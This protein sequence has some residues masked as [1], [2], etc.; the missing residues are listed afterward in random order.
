MPQILNQKALLLSLLLYITHSPLANFFISGVLLLGISNADYSPCKCENSCMC[1]R[2]DLICCI[3]K[4]IYLSY[5]YKRGLLSLSIISSSDIL[6]FFFCLSA[7]LEAASPSG[8]VLG[9]GMGSITERVYTCVT[10]WS[11]QSNKEINLESNT[12]PVVGQIQKTIIIMSS[13]CKTRYLHS[14]CVLV[15]VPQQE[16]E[17]HHRHHHQ[18]LW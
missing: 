12:K 7:A 6:P 4:I 13:L 9:A 10:R 18:C 1:K 17:F 8:H 16:E 5:K 2:N 11:K 15:L 14:L 3:V